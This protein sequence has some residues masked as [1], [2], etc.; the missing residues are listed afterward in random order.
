MDNVRDAS[1]VLILMA[2]LPGSGKSAVAG[3]LARE[4][5]CAVLS[6]DPIEAAMWKAGIERSQPTGLAAYVV[7]ET[8]AREQLRI[9]RD[10]LVDAVNDD[11]AARAQWTSLAAEA[12]WPVAF[13]EVTCSDLTEHRRRLE[14]R[15]RGIAGFPEPTWDAVMTRQE[16]F[17]DWADDRLLVDTVQPLRSIVETARNYIERVRQAGRDG[18]ARLSRQS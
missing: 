12:E 14:A 6:V 11:A 1:N 18:T 2:G 10:A 3:E 17:R 4:L 5:G 8:L 16:G 9:G 15:H 13:I 7:A